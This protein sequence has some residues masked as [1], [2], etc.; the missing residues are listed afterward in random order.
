MALAFIVLWEKDPQMVR[1]RYTKVGIEYT[2]DDVGEGKGSGVMRV[3]YERAM[4]V[5]VA[6]GMGT[7]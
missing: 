6:N 1:G 3:K 2:G 5:Y 7:F 4:D